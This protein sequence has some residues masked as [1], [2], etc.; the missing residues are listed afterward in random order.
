MYH[1]E[2]FLKE[3]LELGKKRK[4]QKKKKPQTDKSVFLSLV[5]KAASRNERICITDISF[6][7]TKEISQTSALR[8]NLP[9]GIY[10]YFKMYFSK[11]H[12]YMS[13][14]IHFFKCKYFH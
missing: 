5:P 2:S 14:Y 11:S 9:L 10:L 13:K 4:K 6:I 7:F 12:R 3:I 8:H 1:T